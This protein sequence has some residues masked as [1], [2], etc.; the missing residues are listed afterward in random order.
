MTFLLLELVVVVVDV[1][2]ALFAD[3]PLRPRAR[4]TCS[5]CD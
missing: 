3:T 5:I 1:V 4:I 2:T